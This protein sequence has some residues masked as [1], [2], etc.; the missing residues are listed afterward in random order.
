MRVL[1]PKNAF[2]EGDDFFLFS[3]NLKNVD[4]RAKKRFFDFAKRSEI[5]SLAPRKIEKFQKDFSGIIY[6]PI[7]MM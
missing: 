1:E 4:A 6:S 5:K 2:L 7:G 3:R